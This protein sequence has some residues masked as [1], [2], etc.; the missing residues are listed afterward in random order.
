LERKPFELF[1]AADNILIPVERVACGVN[2]ARTGA[3]VLQGL[4][5]PDGTDEVVG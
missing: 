3:N 4:R 1:H 2:A 5:R